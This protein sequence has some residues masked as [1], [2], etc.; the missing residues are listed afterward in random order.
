MKEGGK[1]GRKRNTGRHLRV[2]GNNRRK[3]EQEKE[4]EERIKEER[5]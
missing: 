1:W 3:Q 4:R 5:M 2:V